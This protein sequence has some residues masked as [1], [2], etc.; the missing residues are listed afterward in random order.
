MSDRSRIIISGGP[1][2]NTARLYVTL[3][4]FGLSARTS[5]LDGGIDAWREEGR[6]ASRS[7][8]LVTKGNVTLTR[9]PA[10]V[11]DAAWIVG[12][13]ELPATRVRVIDA[14]APEFFVGLAANNTPRA[15]HLPTAANIPFTWMTG[16]LGRFR[17]RPS[18]ERLFRQAGV[19]TGDKVVSYCHIG[20]QASVLYV[21]ARVLGFEA[22]L[23][24][25]SFEDWSRRSELPVST[26]APPRTPIVR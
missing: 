2:T 6:P 5:L 10:R 21:A 4:Y 16:E 19:N 1:I 9:S 17:D 26:G 15:G 7:T 20:M 3:D 12:N 24:D 18:L 25:G 23:Y 11:V 8:P 13:A 14:R 22:A